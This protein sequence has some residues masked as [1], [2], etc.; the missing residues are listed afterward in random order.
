[1]MRSFAPT[2]RGLRLGASLK[3]YV[4][5]SNIGIGT[6]GSPGAWRLSNADSSCPP[7]VKADGGT[8]TWT[9]CEVAKSDRFTWIDESDNGRIRGNPNGAVHFSHTTRR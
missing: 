4:T 5:G 3:E 1:M 6:F 9:C 8:T 7:L 2:G